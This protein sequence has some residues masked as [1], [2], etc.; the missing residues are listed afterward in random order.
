MTNALRCLSSSRSV[1]NVYT[2]LRI[3]VSGPR[4]ARSVWLPRW[5]VDDVPEFF[6]VVWDASMVRV[7]CLCNCFFVL[8]LL[9]LLS[10]YYYCCFIFWLLLYFVIILIIIIVVT[11]YLFSLFLSVYPSTIYRVIYFL[12]AFTSYSSVELYFLNIREER[13]KETHTEKEKKRVRNREIN[14]KYIVLYSK[15]IK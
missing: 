11:F 12:N 13:K 3:R 8:L 2:L 4:F 1:Y 10:L 14:Q 15:K 7:R 9:L 6:F 5:W